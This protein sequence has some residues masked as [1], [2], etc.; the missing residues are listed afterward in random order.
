[1]KIK[2]ISVFAENEPRRLL[3]ILAGLD[4]AG[5]NL[6]AISVS[7]NAEFGIVRMIASD[8]E[9]GVEALK[10]AGFTARL[11]SLLTVE[12]PDEPSSLLKRV[13]APLAAARINI[14]YFYAF[15]EAKAGTARIVLKTSDDEKAEVILGAR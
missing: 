7:E 3:A 5:V 11:D 1:M 13:A 9:K 15:L 10:K 2:Q 14:N 6:R 4:A 8:A 12:L